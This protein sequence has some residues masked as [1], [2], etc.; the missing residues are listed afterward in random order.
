VSVDF[1]SQC[2]LGELRWADDELRGPRFEALGRVSV[3]SGRRLVLNLDVRGAGQLG[4]VTLDEAGLIDTV[5]ATGME[6]VESDLEA[7]AGWGSLRKL[8][9]QD[10]P[11]ADLDVSPL[12]RLSSLEFLGLKGTGVTSEQ[13]RPVGNLRRLRRLYLTSD[14]VDDLGPLRP[15]SLETLA[16]SG[17][18]V[19][20]HDLAPVAEMTGLKVLWLTNTAVTSAALSYLAAL[21]QLE[22]LPLGRTGVSDAHLDVLGSLPSLRALDLTSTSITT[23]GLAHICASGS[24]RELYLDSTRLDDGAVAILGRLPLTVVSVQGA[25]VSEEGVER[26]RG[27]VPSA[28]VNGVRRESN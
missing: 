4:R 1:G 11:L 10:V 7:I 6:L 5:R 8:I 14:P 3:P 12:W 24:L 9:L 25:G 23:A 26:L 21:P 17:T 19:R 28:V 2:S 18:R 16:L 22:K 27:L 13:L 15:L 20:D